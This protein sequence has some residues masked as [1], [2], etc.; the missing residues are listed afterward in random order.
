MRLLH[1]YLAREVILG[2]ALV[3]AA[4]V[5]LFSFFD[6]IHELNDLGK[7]SYQITQ[8]IIYVLLAMP[9]HGYELFPI[10]ALIGTLYGLNT[11]AQ[12]S[13]ITVMR[14]SGMSK[15]QLNR[16]MIRIGL[17][18]VVLAFVLGEFVVPATEEAAQQWRLKALNNFVATQFRSG[19]WVKDDGSFINIREMLPDNSLRDI[20]I[21]RFDTNRRLKEISRAQSASF[22]SEHKWRLSQVE[23]TFFNQEGV[24]VSRD[25]NEEWN[26]VLS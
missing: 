10:A 15:L 25:D 17:Y 8:I 24:N 6:F 5:S 18:F 12:H 3:F 2:T 11:L 7:G 1:R 4:L 9:G 14:A 16:S 21:Y 22:I 20:R 23:H 26:S 13:E 19:I